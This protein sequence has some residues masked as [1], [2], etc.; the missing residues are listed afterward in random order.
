MFIDCR[1]LA[2]TA[3]VAC[4]AAS[5][6]GMRGTELANRYGSYL[7]R[8]PSD[9]EV[10]PLACGERGTAYVGMWLAARVAATI[11]NW[12]RGVPPAS[13]TVWQV[14]ANVRMGGGGAREQAST[15]E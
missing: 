13:L 5:E 3:A 14:G 8:L 7:A 11:N 6:S 12:C 10:P 2:E 1:V 9:D 4:V 15:T